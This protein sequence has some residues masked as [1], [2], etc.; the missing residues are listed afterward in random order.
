MRNYSIFGGN[1]DTSEDRIDIEPVEGEKDFSVWVPYGG[2]VIEPGGWWRWEADPDEEDPY[3]P[4]ELDDPSNNTG[5]VYGGDSGPGYQTGP[6]IPGS[7][8]PR[9]QGRL[10]RNSRALQA[11]RQVTPLLWRYGKAKR[12]LMEDRFGNK[13]DN[14]E[15]EMRLFEDWIE[16]QMQKNLADVSDVIEEALKRAKEGDPGLL[17]QIVRLYRMFFS[18]PVVKPTPSMDE[19]AKFLRDSV[20]DDAVVL[21]RL[22]DSMLEL[23]KKGGPSTRDATNFRPPVFRPYYSREY[24]TLKELLGD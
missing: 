4:G 2:D 12:T 20:E 21:E 15:R 5:T 22:I 6:R 7:F 19:I 13:Y 11:R 23:F 16:R 18:Q 8:V 9:R 17:T 10:S 1:V 24:K 3:D 14:Y